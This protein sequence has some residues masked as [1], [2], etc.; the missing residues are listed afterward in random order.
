MFGLGL[1]S[2]AP[3]HSTSTCIPQLCC[4]SSTEIQTWMTDTFCWLLPSWCS[5]LCGLH[6]LSTDQ[7]GSCIRSAVV[8][9]DQSIINGLRCCTWHNPSLLPLLTV[10]VSFHQIDVFLLNVKTSSSSSLDQTVILVFSCFG[11]VK[12]QCLQKRVHHLGWGLNISKR[13]VCILIYLGWARISLRTS[14]S[15]LL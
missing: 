10:P 12:L 2:L 7:A 1:C 4:W 14:S 5:A 6:A 8:I 13:N 9:F 15:D 11:S 3:H